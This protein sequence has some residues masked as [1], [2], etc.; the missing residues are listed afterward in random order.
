[1][2]YYGRRLGSTKGDPEDNTL[3]VV[4]VW[5]EFTSGQCSRK[6]GHGARGLYCKQHAN[7]GPSICALKTPE[8]EPEKP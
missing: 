7:M 5:H 4:E 1:M 8:D 3:C 2:K 6:R